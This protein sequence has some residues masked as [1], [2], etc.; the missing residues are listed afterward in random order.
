MIQ[1]VVTLLDM[2]FTFK[3]S[4]LSSKRIWSFFCGTVIWQCVHSFDGLIMVM[5]NER[6]T[7]LKKNLFASSAPPSLTMKV[8]PSVTISRF[9][10][11]IE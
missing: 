8:A 4:L 1:D 2:I 10:A 7:F 11:R 5:F 6:L 9:T 3:L